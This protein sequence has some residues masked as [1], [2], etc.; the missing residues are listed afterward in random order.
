[1]YSPDPQ[2]QQYIVDCHRISGDVIPFYMFFR[3]FHSLLNNISSEGM[4]LEDEAED[5][6]REFILACATNRTETVLK[7]IGH[8]LLDKNGKDQVGPSHSC[9][10]FAPS[11]TRCVY[12]FRMAAPLFMLPAAAVTGK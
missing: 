10:Q 8:P 2:S 5:L 4:F 3:E 11:L 1:V 6:C 7:L 9:F 12:L